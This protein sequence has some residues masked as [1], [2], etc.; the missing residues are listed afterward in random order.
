MNFD[1]MPPPLT[2]PPRVELTR[3]QIRALRHRETMNTSR[4]GRQKQA[5]IWNETGGHCVYCGEQVDPVMRTV[6][7]IW[8][9]SRGGTRADRNLIPA[10]QGCNTDRG[11]KFP[12]SKFAAP[13]WSGYV[14]RKETML[15][16]HPGSNQK[17]GD[18]L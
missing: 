4:K 14:S 17:G 12:A 10:C 6:D 16:L 9:K 7:H 3:K 1:D 2:L 8:P 13:E 15:G 18:A 5:R 11:N